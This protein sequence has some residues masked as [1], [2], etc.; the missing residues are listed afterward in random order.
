MLTQPKT[1][2]PDVRSQKKEFFS[3]PDLFKKV[4][5]RA[6]QEIEG[7]MM[8][9]RFAKGETIFREDDPAG[10]IW[11]VKQGHVKEVNHSRDGHSK[12][13]CMTGP[14]GM[15]GISALG[16]GNYDFHSLAV[17]DSTLLSFPIRGFKALM[18]SNPEVASAVAF[19]VSK[20]LRR[21]MGARAVFRE[22]AEKRLLF[23]LVEMVQEFGNH[24]PLTRKAIAEMAGVAVETC[25]R[26]F[27]PLEEE[28]LI[29]SAHGNFT[30]MNV[31]S[32]LNR[33]EEL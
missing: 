10:F 22:S 1:Q 16:G 11:F 12:T 2:Q 31:G 25:I 29:Q 14:G 17:T 8:E 32:L 19:F 18:A 4:P 9:K 21:S 6:L 20:T 24:I 5:S 28:G 3:L 23:T 27:T 13:L 30:V 7:Q 33:M 26:I 15:F